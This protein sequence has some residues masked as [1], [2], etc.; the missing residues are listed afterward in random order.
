MTEAYK[1]TK[2]YQASAGEMLSEAA[3]L[4][5]AA[6]FIYFLAHK[7]YAMSAVMASILIL[8]FLLL[9]R[10][11]D[12]VFFLIGLMAGGGNDLLSMYKGVYAY[13]PPHDFTDLPIP[14]WMLFF[15][16]EVFIFFRKLMRFGPFLGKSGCITKWIDW[17][18]AMDLVV[19]IGYRMLIYRTASHAWLPD[20]LF[21]AILV[22][23]LLLVPPKSNE[24]KLMLIMLLLG[25]LYEIILIAAGLYRY[26]TG[27]VFGMPLW[28]IV[29]W[30][31]VV[32]FLKAIFDRVENLLAGV[33]LGR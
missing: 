24:R 22:V 16:G 6:G 8:R 9:N 7:T 23:R 2:S 27:V 32:R 12:Y 31:F 15:W 10:R 28:L 4:L 1:T 17:P 20:A 13:L 14:A 26:Q 18:L 33:A 29:Y 19:V 5:V 30:V 21:A 11:G 3:V 25:P